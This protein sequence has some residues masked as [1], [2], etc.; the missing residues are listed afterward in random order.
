MLDLTTYMGRLSAAGIRFTTQPLPAAVAAALDLAEQVSAALTPYQYAFL[1]HEKALTEVRQQ[2]QQQHQQP[3]PQPPLPMPPVHLTPLQQQ[4]QSEWKQPVKQFASI[5]GLLQINGAVNGENMPSTAHTLLVDAQ[6]LMSLAA[7]LLCF[8]GT[9]LLQQW[10]QQLQGEQLQGEQQL[11][12]EQQ[13]QQQQ[14]QQRERHAAPAA[15]GGGCGG[16]SS[17]SSGSSSM[18]AWQEA[19]GL[20]LL[21]AAALEAPAASAAP[22][23]QQQQQ[24]LALCKQYQLQFQRAATSLGLSAELITAVAAWFA[25]AEKYTT[26]SSKSSSSSSS[27]AAAGSTAAAADCLSS[28]CAAS[29]LLALASTLIDPLDKAGAK[30][31]QLTAADELTLAGFYMQVINRPCCLALLSFPA[32]SLSKATNQPSHPKGTARGC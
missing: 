22:Q 5:P 25:E 8:C 12:D 7:P 19:E 16:S 26:T 30:Q 1:A 28:V 27:P 10:E 3:P 29:L 31:R 15:A 13:Q 4:Q 14:Q 2:Q 32:G 11:Q 18:P 6:Q 24:Q 20:L 17:G 21:G 9:R 23:Y